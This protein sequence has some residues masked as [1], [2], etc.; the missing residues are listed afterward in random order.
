MQAMQ[1]AIQAH[2]AGDLQL[3]IQAYRAAIRAAPTFAEAHHNLGIALKALGQGMAAEKAL[4][5]AVRLRPDYAMAHAALAN[6]Y[7]RAGDPTKAL[8]Q[9]LTAYAALPRDPVVVNN[10]V[11]TLG[12]MR[13]T[14]ADPQLAAILTGL[15]HRDDVEGQR[16]VGAGLSLLALERPIRAALEASDPTALPAAAPALLLALLERTVIADRDWE[17]LLTRLRAELL[18]D[19]RSLDNDRAPLAQA[20]AAQMLATDF[21]CAITEPEAETL[22]G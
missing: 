8:R 18:V 19:F 3:A 1:A 15:L 6:H 22:T 17:H 10:L 5:E 4:R 21:A 14:Q 7:E 9:W 2:R 11:R 20:L 12:R 16:L 13:F